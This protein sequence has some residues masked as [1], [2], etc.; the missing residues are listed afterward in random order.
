MLKSRYYF[1]IHLFN[2]YYL[3]KNPFLFIHIYIVISFNQ[4]H[5]VLSLYIQYIYISWSLWEFILLF[6]SRQSRFLTT[7]CVEEFLGNQV[8]LNAFP[9]S[10]MLHL[11]VLF[12]FEIVIFIKKGFLFFQKKQNKQRKAVKNRKWIFE[13]VLLTC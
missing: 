1:S 13:H 11:L 6:I 10:T 4:Y 7:K 8:L 5:W 12:F 3:K 2:Y 9:M